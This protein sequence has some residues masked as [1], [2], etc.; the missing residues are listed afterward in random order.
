MPG[1]FLFSY[2]PL[3]GNDTVFNASLLGS[4]LLAYCYKY[5]KKEEYREAA[6]RSVE[7]CCDAQGMPANGFTECFLCSRG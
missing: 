7:A 5:T 6:R 4:K 2:S 1:G 3:K